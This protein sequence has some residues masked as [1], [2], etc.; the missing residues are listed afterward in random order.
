MLWGK[1]DGCG[2][3]RTRGEGGK[4]TAKSE[5]RLDPSAAPLR[6]GTWMTISVHTATHAQ[7]AEPLFCNF[8]NEAFGIII[9]LKG[10]GR[11]IALRE[12]RTVFQGSHCPA[13]RQHYLK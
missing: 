4:A 7:I 5:L 11:R 1:E 3:K 6:E 9:K 2:D 10:K 13:L 8:H 12:L